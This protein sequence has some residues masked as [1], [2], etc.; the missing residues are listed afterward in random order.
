[1]Y[2]TRSADTDVL[3]IPLAIDVQKRRKLSI[4]PHSPMGQW[5]IPWDAHLS[6]YRCVCVPLSIPSH[7][8]MGQWGCPLHPHSPMEQWDIKWDVHM[9]LLQILPLFIPFYD[10]MKVRTHASVEGQVDILWKVPWGCG[11]GWTIPC[12]P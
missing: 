10:P 4:P 6:L 1:M 11:I 5:D 3:I 9:S 12:N 7:G 8:P 2:T